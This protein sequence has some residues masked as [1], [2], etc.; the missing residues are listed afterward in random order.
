MNVYEAH[1]RQRHENVLRHLC[2]SG[3][4]SDQR[5][6]YVKYVIKEVLDEYKWI[7]EITFPMPPETGTDPE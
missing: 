4:P 2:M 7:D 1:H 6:Y 3:T 5:E